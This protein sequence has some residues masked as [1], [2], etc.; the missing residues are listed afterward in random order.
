MIDNLAV[1]ARSRETVT[2]RYKVGIF[3]SAVRSGWG[4]VA[5]STRILGKFGDVTPYG[6]GDVYVSWYP[7]ALMAHCRGERPPAVPRIDDDQHKRREIL[8]GLGINGTLSAD[9]LNGNAV[10]R[11]GYV[12][13]GGAGD[14]SETSSGL[15][16]RS[17]PDARELAPGYVSVDTGKYTL[18][19]MLARKAADLVRRRLG[20]R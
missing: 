7:A 3:A 16:H 5:P 18:G 1:V 9:L 10:V 20:L 11:G 12:V 17:E 19:P 2:I 8:S 15:H 4:G 14:I 13:A 6:N